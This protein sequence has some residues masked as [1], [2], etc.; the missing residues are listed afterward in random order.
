MESDQ[1]NGQQGIYQTQ[2]TESCK[3][4]HS[5]AEE[6]RKNKGKIKEIWES[7]VRRQIQAAEGQ[8]SIALVNS[9]GVFLD[10]LAITLDQDDPSA[11]KSSSKNGMSKIHG[12]QRANFGKYFLPQLLKEFSILREVLIEELHKA[13]VL[14]FGVRNQIDDVLD[15]AISLAATEFAA[16]QQASTT[17]T[18]KKAEMSNQD[19]EHFAAVAAHDLKS[20]LATISG[21]LSLLADES[22]D[23][24]NKD[25]IEYIDVMA[26]ASER[27]RSLIDR[28]LEFA[29][30][31]KVDRPFGSVNIKNIV[32]T[33]LVNLTDSVQKTSAKV[34][35]GPLPVVTGD[36]DLLTQLFQNL[37]A[38]AIKFHGSEPPEI[39]IEAKD[40]DGMWTV[41]ITDNGIGF[42]SKDKENIFTLYKKL[43]GDTDYQGAGIGL[44]TCRKVVEL[45]GGKIWAASKPGL[46]ST[47]Y[48]TLPKPVSTNTVIHH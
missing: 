34:T 20:P 32:E 28:L 17:R 25:S 46:G 8:T 10:E 15:S 41:S 44:A 11:D 39:R 12:G 40:K 48:F 43:H 13:D 3:V 45:H 23:I 22:K 21:Y 27:M 42:D 9:L 1:V 6:L 4:Y 31:T 33:T 36:V 2:Q 38:N 35:Y 16:T 30:L 37:I 5:A 26:K 24:L 14:T 18:L 19:L 7:R 47:F 29:R